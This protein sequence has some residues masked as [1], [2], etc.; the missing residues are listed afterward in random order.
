ME[1]VKMKMTKYEMDKSIIKDLPPFTKKELEEV[2]ED[3]ISFL[4]ENPQT[5]HFMLLSN[6]INY[7]TILTKQP[8]FTAHYS[9]D[10]ILNFL[11]ENLFLKSLGK[12][13]VFKRTGETMEIWIGESHFR[14]FDAD[15]LFV[16]V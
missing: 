16:E 7:Y 8:L 6:E 2:R 14:L 12:L 13:K 5:R 1:K 4:K 11:N 15:H 3:L 10:S 9:A